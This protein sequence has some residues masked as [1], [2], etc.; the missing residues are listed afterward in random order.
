MTR[1]GNYPGLVLS[2]PPPLDAVLEHN[3]DERTRFPT[4]LDDAVDVRLEVG[5]HLR[6]GQMLVGATRPAASAIQR[7]SATLSSSPP[8]Y[9]S[10]IVCTTKPRA[11]IAS[12]T[13]CRPRL[14]STKNSGGGCGARR[15]KGGEDV[16]ERHAVVVG[17][18]LRGLARFDSAL[19]VCHTSPAVHEYRL[20]E[21][22][23]RVGEKDRWTE[24]VPG[25][26]RT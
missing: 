18:R 1:R 4:A 22:A 13:M 9:T 7:P 19:D 6:T 23:L 26:G 10:A 15:G 24:R 14:R 5:I 21:G 12:G 11:L 25:A 8:G 16:V 20:A 3:I 2:R 17:D